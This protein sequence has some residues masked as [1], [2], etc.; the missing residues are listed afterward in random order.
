MLYQD[1]SSL[2]TIQTVCAKDDSLYVCKIPCGNCEYK[3]A[4]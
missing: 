4:I 1:K 3:R 2:L